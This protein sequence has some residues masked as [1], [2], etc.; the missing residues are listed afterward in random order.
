[1]SSVKGRYSWPGDAIYSV[2]KHSI[3]TMSDSL[4]MEM[5]KFGIKVS[6]IEPGSYGAA[7]ALFGPAQ[8]LF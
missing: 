8:V 7:T 4:R 6:V 1:M 2:T 3:E 5:I